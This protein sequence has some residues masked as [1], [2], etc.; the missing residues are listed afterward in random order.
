MLFVGR[1]FTTADALSVGI[2]A[3]TLRRLVREGTVRRLMAGVYVDSAAE[4]TPE[5]RA[6]AMV[7]VIDDNAVVCDR[8]AAWLHGVDVLGPEG[9]SSVPRLEVYRTGGQNRTRRTQCRGGKR[10]LSPDDVERVRG[11]PVTTPLRTAMDLGRFLRRYEAIGALDALMRVGGLTADD[12]RRELFRFRGARG[13][14]QLR[15]LIE[16]ADP[17]SESMAESRLRLEMSDNGL[18]E[19]EVQWVI[20]NERGNVLYRLD[21]AYPDLMLAIEYDGRDFHTSPADRER[22]RRRREHLRRMGWTVL[23]LQAADV[24]GPAPT[25]IRKIWAARSR[26]IATA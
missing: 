12:L 26:L 4:E 15:G 16:R 24:Y 11:V 18:P 19:P 3:K 21:L 5:L 13:V 6:Q 1:P 7:H 14:V 8:S 25:A 2:S 23:V 10:T 22:D 17:R 9:L 20:R